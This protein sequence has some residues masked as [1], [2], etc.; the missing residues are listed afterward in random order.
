[1]LKQ[2]PGWEKVAQ[3]FLDT[4]HPFRDYI[5]LMA[6]AYG[7]GGH[8]ASWAKMLS[9]RWANISK[10]PAHS[11]ATWPA[12]MKNGDLTAWREMLIGRLVGAPQSEELERTLEDDQAWQK[13]DLTLLPDSRRGLRCEFWFYEAMRYKAQGQ[14]GQ[15]GMHECLRR[16]VETGFAAY[17]EHAMATFLLSQAG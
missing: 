16:C 6:Y 2:S 7:G 3:R 9:E 17:W 12:R 14:Q 11:P 4:D 8:S 13:S 5:L 15:S 1:M 10:D